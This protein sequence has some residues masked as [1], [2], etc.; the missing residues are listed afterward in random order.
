MG[1]RIVASAEVTA[2][3]LLDPQF[4]RRLEEVHVQPERPIQ[5]SQLPVRGLAFET[6]IAD[7]L[8]D[9]RAILLLDVALVVLLRDPPAGERDVLPFAVRQEFGIQELAAVVR[10]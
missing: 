1:G 5:L 4:H 8:P 6:V 2:F 10:V 7:D 9:D 3:A